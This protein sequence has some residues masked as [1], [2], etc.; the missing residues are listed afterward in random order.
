MTDLDSSAPAGTIEAG[1]TAAPGGESF[2]I[3]GGAGTIAT[4]APPGQF[5]D[6]WRRF[7]RNKLAML[8]LFMIFLVAMVAIFAPVLA[9]YNPLKQNLSATLKGPSSAH[10][11]GTDQ[12]G[13]DQFSRIIFGSR[14]AFEVGVAS[15]ML[16]VVIGLVLGSLAG[17]L[18]RKWDSVIMRVA[19]V[20]F[21]FPLLI[22]AILFIL[23]LGRGTVPVILA[24]GVFSWATVGRLLRSSILSVREAEYIEAARSLGAGKFRIVTR[25]VLPNSLAPVIVYAAVSVGVAIVAEVSLA[26]LGAGPRADTADWG[27]MIS[28]GQSFLGYKDFMWFFPSMAVVFTVLG[29]VFMGD[30]IRDALDPKLR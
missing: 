15:I 8:G 28:A 24:L 18:G 11:M 30:G 22:G 16:A 5:S 25:H 12:N 26:Y 4:A 21:A 20:F 13:R 1:V 14:I 29:F 9:P 3:A 6:N 27:N 10:W 19:D 17:Y 23:V 2:A 7:R